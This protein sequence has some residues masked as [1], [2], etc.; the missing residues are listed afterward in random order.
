MRRLILNIGCAFVLLASPAV[1]LAQATK[2][3]NGT[4]SAIAG[5]SVTVTVDGKEM[6]F[7]V[8]GKTQVIVHGGGTKSREAKA[9]GKSGTTVADLLKTGQAVEVKYHEA[10]MHAASI[11]AIA[12]V[13][14]PSKSHTASGV[15]SAITGNSLTV[16]GA[17]AEWTFSVDNKTMVV[18]SGVGTAGKKLMSEGKTTGLSDLLHEGDTVSVTYEDTGATKVASTVRITKRKS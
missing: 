5:D 8:D 6:K 11:R 7:A 10:G 17:S 16:K 12:S 4:I 13:P 2:T 1:V 3:A 18:G 9:E 15:V 14:S